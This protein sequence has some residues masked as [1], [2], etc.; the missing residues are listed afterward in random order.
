MET[1]AETPADFLAGLDTVARRVA[2]QVWQDG[3]VGIHRSALCQRGELMPAELP[4]SLARMGHALRRFQ[5]ER[6]VILSRPVAA[7]SPLQGYFVDA[8]FATAAIWQMFD[9]RMSRHLSDC[10]GCP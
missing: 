10:A 7:N 5:R 2:R 1:P 4:S 9:K 6:G 8:D 3:A